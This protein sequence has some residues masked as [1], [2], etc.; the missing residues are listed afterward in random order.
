MVGKV[1]T[2]EKGKYFIEGENQEALQHL[3]DISNQKAKKL[4]E[5]IKDG[6]NYN[7]WLM[8]S[9]VA[10]GIC[11]ASA[12]GQMNRSRQKRTKV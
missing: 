1:M 10:E 2:R 6:K 8:I 4:L 9:D 7:V 12:S 5:Q 3:R 11:N